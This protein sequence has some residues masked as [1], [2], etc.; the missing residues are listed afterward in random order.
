MLLFRK[1]NQSPSKYFIIQLYLAQKS[2]FNPDIQSEMEKFNTDPAILKK[3]S[4]RLSEV[5]E[6]K[7]D[8]F[9]GALN[10]QKMIT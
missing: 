10:I 9:K 8:L 3:Y 2:I 5:L 6:G 1:S 4:F 7:L